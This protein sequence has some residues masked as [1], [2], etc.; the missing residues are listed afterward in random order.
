MKIKINVH[1]AASVYDLAKGD[2]NFSDSGI[3]TV[4]QRVYSVCYRI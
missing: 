3:L 2:Q 4:L 1:S